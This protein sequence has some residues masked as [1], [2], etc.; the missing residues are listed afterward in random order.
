MDEMAAHDHQHIIGA[1]FLF[2]L[3]DMV[4]V[5]GMEGIIFSYDSGCFHRIT[6]RELCFF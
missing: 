2:C 1:G 3:F 6:S 4:S 5:A